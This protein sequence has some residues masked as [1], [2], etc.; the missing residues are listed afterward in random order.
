MLPVYH[1]LTYD[2]GT[3]IW[4]IEKSLTSFRKSYA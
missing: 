2:I 1:L 3:T 4:A